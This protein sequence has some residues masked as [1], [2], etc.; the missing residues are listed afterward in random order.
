MF[1]HQAEA[2]A[3]QPLTKK[4]SSLSKIADGSTVYGA[5]EKAFYTLVSEWHRRPACGH[6]DACGVPCRRPATVRVNFHGCHT[7]LL[8]TEHLEDWRRYCADLLSHGRGEPCSICWAVFYT[9][10][11]VCTVIWL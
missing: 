10:D 9:V 2:A 6:A 5:T 7:K 11:D 1:E 4:G 8:C 3:N